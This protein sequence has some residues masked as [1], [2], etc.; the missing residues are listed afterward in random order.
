LRANVVRNS[1]VQLVPV[2]IGEEYGNTVQVLA[3]LTPEDATIWN[4]SDSLADGAEV[5]I[6]TAQPIPTPH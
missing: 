3:G 5:H 6:E 4:P 1:H 2:T